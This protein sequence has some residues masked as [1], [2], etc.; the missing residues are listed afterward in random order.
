M[1]QTKNGPKSNI[2]FCYDFSLII[3][4]NGGLESTEYKFIIN[5]DTSRNF[6]YCSKLSRDLSNVIIQDTINRLLTNLELDSIFE[7]SKK[8]F[9]IY[10]NPY[11]YDPSK[12]KFTAPYDGAYATVIFKPGMGDDSYI[13]EIRQADNEYCS[14]KAYIQLFKYLK[15]II[16]VP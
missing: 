12:V 13:A 4:H 5:P 7:L 15:I 14:N 6:L 11:K 16:N 10:H 8:I 1:S 3:D 9:V 2:H